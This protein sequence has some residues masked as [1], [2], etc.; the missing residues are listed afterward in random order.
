MSLRACIGLRV[1]MRMFVRIYVYVIP[2]TTDLILWY[3]VMG[4]ILKFSKQVLLLFW[5][6]GRVWALFCTKLWSNLSVMF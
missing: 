6:F 3:R 1:C 2:E 5:S 4:P